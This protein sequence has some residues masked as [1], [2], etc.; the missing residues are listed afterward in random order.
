MRLKRRGRKKG[1][2]IKR[3]YNPV[4]TE[5]CKEIKKLKKQQL[6]L[7]N[8]L[9][10]KSQVRSMHKRIPVITELKKSSRNQQNQ[11]LVLKKRLQRKKKILF[12]FP[13]ARAKMLKKIKKQIK[14]LGKQISLN[15]AAVAT[16]NANI[17]AS[18]K[19][20]SM[21][22]LKELKER[23]Q[24]LELKKLSPEELKNLT[25][26]KIP[27]DQWSL[28]SASAH[29][30]DGLRISYDKVLKKLENMERIVGQLAKR[31]EAIDP[32]DLEDV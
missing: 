21:D 7:E 20:P 9:K 11:I 1:S 28:I 15:D 2:K 29:K 13:K 4:I 6:A 18:G 32:D 27:K 16:L 8:K 19:Q 26:L 22:L 24:K 30:F 14:E 23:V 25:E 17:F 5:L 3:L 10:K 31:V 12:K